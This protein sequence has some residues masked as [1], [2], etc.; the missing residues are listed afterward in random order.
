MKSMELILILELIMLAE[1]SIIQ[2]KQNT[3]LIVRENRS[4]RLFP[5][6]SKLKLEQVLLVWEVVFHLEFL[7]AI[8][9]KLINRQKVLNLILEKRLTWREDQGLVLKILWIAWIIIVT[10][11]F[12]DNQKFKALMC[13]CGKLFKKVSLILTLVFTGSYRIH[14]SAFWNTSLILIRSG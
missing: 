2:L 5:T 6:R 4:K 8:V 12:L 3:T 13:Q 10:G 9:L 1:D 14:T 11:L 7:T